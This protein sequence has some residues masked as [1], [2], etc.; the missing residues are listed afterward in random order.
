MKQTKL[1]RYGSSSYVN[2]QKA[3]ETMLE[4]YGTKSYF[5]TDDFKRLSYI[6]YNLNFCIILN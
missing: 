4:R 6:K 3:K 2:S 1:E 5:G